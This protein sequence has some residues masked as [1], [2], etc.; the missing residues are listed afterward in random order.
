MNKATIALICCSTLFAACDNSNDS[1]KG[2]GSMLDKATSLASDVADSA[3]DAT[4]GAL[5]SAKNMAGNAVD[6]AKESAVG[7]ID[8]AKDAAVDAVASGKDLKEAAVEGASAAVDSAKE[9]MSGAIEG[10][11]D[12]GKDMTSAVTDKTSEVV[13]SAS[14]A[15]SELTSSSAAE[16]ESI[17]KAKCSACHNTG[18]AG[19]PKLVE[20]DAWTARIAQG[21]EVMTKHA[22][23]GFKGETGF[24]P[25]KG[26]FMT[27]SDDEI[28]AAV[29]YMVSQVN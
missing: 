15:V 23:E 14:G 21:N 2:E 7:A 3:K 18:V 9:S 12:A 17:Y 11:V 22:I 13:A 5:D 27:L 10:A 26:G 19:A 24:M 28:A 16:G 4:G 8:A 1:A 6:S 29:E 25:P 20:K